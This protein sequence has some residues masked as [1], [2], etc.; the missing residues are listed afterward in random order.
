MFERV[1]PLQRADAGHF[2]VLGSAAHRALAREAVRKSLVLLKNERAL[3]PLNP[4]G[5][6]AGGR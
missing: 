5:T 2:E 6:R 1:P 3:L 4:R